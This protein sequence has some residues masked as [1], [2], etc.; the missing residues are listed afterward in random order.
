MSKRNSDLVRLAGEHVFK[1]FRG[2]GQDPPLV[3][4]GFRRSRELVDACKDVAKGCELA[5]ADIEAV[6]LAAWFHDTCYATGL[7]DD[8]NRSIQLCREFLVHHHAP[9]ELRDRVV[10][11]LE[12]LD[13]TDHGAHDAREDLLHH[14]GDE[15]D[16][17]G[18][19]YHAPCDVLYDGLLVALARKNFVEEAELLRLEVE[20]REGK[21]FSDV[22]WTQRC[23]EFVENHP[24]RTRFAQLEYNGRRA[25]NLVR[26][27]KLLRRQVEDAEEERAEQAKLSRGL[28]KTIE[29]VFYYL[30]RFQ[31]QLV[32]IADRRTSTMVHVNAIMI[33]IVVALLLRR[34]DSQRYLLVPTLVLLSVNLA[35]IVVSIYS[36]R[37]ARAKLLADESRIHDSNLLVFTNDISVSFPEYEDRMNHLASDVPGMQRS[38]IE[39]MYF[40]R[41]LLVDR[42][43]ALRVTYDVFIYGLALSLLAFAVALVR[44]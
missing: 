1:L 34:L 17:A 24:Y 44:R 28:G 29:S 40:V 20:R 21:T 38:M 9:E 37:A 30:T 42:Q 27:H 4:H 11:C 41:K 7:E 13:D 22:D 16:G 33:S 3:Y 18:L 8:R 31:V 23:I 36:M 5:G 12:G 15:H 26:L 10:A 32:G 35:T 6:L 39:H 14:G 43:R 2:V 19:D 25:A